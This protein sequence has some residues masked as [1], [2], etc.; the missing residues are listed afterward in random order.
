MRNAANPNNKRMQS[1]RINTPTLLPFFGGV[2]KP[3]AAA[4]PIERVSSGLGGGG[5]T[6]AG[7]IAGGAMRAILELA[8]IRNIVTKSIGSNNK[9]NVVKATLEGLKRIKTPSE[10]ARLRGKSLQE[11]QEG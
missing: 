9:H 11:I 1:T 2:S 10:V 6:D 4:E 8:G 3:Y 5:V 7:V